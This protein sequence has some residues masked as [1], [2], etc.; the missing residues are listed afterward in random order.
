M[1]NYCLQQRLFGIIFLYDGWLLQEIK[2]ELI[3]NIVLIQ[4]LSHKVQF[5]HLYIKTNMYEDSFYRNVSTKGMRHWH[6][7]K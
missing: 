7:Y 4:G 3:F 5:A 1:F 6:V 2:I